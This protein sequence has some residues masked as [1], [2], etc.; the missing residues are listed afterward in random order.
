M[1]AFWVRASLSMGVFALMAATATAQGLPGAA[2]N[3]VSALQGMSDCRRIADGAERLACYDKAA[4]LLDEAEAKGDIVVADRE[5]MRQ[6]RRQ[7]FGFTL[8]S[9]SLFDRGDAQDAGKLTLKIQ[10]ATQRGDGKWLFVLEGG[11]VWR[12][13]DT[14]ALPRTPKSGGTVTISRAALGS[15]KLNAGGAGAIRVHRDQ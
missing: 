10:S 13:I 8:P 6:V 1:T 5:Q 7:A 11:Q 4:A 3:R 12:Q 15:Y 2:K 9:L 14:E